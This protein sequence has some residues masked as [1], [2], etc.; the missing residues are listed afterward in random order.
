ML[1][2]FWTLPTAFLT[3]TAAAAGIALINSVGT[4][5]GFAGPYAMGWLKD[6]TKTFT[7]PLT[8][9]SVTL[10]IGGFLALAV[11]PVT[12]RKPAEEIP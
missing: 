3:G 5:G 9:L 11:R 7:A 10:C 8:A 12:V 6:T 2:P 1:G 4:L